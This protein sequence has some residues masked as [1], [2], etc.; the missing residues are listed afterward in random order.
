MSQCNDCRSHSSLYNSRN[1]QLSIEDI[2]SFISSW[3]LLGNTASMLCILDNPGTLTSQI[4]ATVYSSSPSKERGSAELT[5][6]IIEFQQFC[7]TRMQKGTLHNNQEDELNTNIKP[8]SLST[9]CCY[10]QQHLLH[11]LQQFNQL[12]FPHL[13]NSYS[14]M[15]STKE[16]K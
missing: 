9:K 1:T 10:W 12:Q 7:I 4:A 6:N 15:Q 5:L 8:H 13:Q 11:R 2:N 14:S 3:Y 16:L